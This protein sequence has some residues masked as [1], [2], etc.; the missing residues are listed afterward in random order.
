MRTQLVRTIAALRKNE[1]HL[2]VLLTLESRL[3]R[4]LRETKARKARRNDMEAGM[5]VATR[6]QQREQLPNFEE[7]SRPCGRWGG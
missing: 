5:V 4:R 1:T 3:M 2:G 6:R 7:V